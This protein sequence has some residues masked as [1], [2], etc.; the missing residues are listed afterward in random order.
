MNR[1]SF[2]AGCSLVMILSCTNTNSKMA[3]FTWLNGTWE[4]KGKTRTTYEVW[5]PV[6]DS[7]FGGDS[8]SVKENK[9]TI[10]FEVIRF[11]YRNGVYYYIPVAKG[12]NDDIPVPFKLTS[13]SEKGFV[14]E[15]PEHDFP[16]R[17]VYELIHTDSIHAFVDNGADT[18]VMRS[19]FYFSRSKK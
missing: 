7:T 16:K 6:N 19:D 14:A 2:F 9:D 1:L 13:H 3:P 5:S 12:Q 11:V 4:M 18:P 8:Y 17:I 15:N 10:P